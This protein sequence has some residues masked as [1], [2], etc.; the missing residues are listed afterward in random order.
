VTT[1]QTVAVREAT[2]DEL[3]AAGE[4]VRAA[5]AADG[6]G[7]EYYH[8]VL[9]DARTRARD[10]TVVVAV[11]GTGRVVGSVTYALPGSRWA[12]VAGDGEAEFRMLGVLPS[13]RGLGVGAALTQ[14]CIDRARA[15]GRQRLVLS[16]EQ[17][18]GSAHRLY[19]RRGFARRAEADWSPVAGVLLLGFS[20]ELD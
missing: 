9:A 11:D 10:A 17:S 2:D 19:L 14:W 20:L 13:H 12:E 3:D 6:H 18:M 1:I 7:P 8:A 16:S 4:A 15:D 5:Y